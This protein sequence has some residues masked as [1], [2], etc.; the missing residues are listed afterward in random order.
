VHFLSLLAIGLEWEITE[1]KWNPVEVCAH[2][3]RLL[4]FCSYDDLIGVVRV[5]SNRQWQTSVDFHI[6]PNRR[7]VNILQN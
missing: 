2:D 4:Q 3:N 6:H 1:W 5:S 7:W